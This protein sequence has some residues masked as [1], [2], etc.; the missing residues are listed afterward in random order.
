MDY[1]SIRIP[2]LSNSKIKEKA[3]LFHKDFCDDSIP[4]EIEGIIDLKLKFNIIPVSNLQKL[5]DTDALITSNWDSIYVDSDKFLDERYSNRL[6]FSLAHEIGHFIL[7]KDIYKNFNIKTY[8]DF[9]RLLKDIPSEEY[10]YLESQANKFASHLLIPR[11]KLNNEKIRE[12]KRLESLGKIDD[13]II[14]T[15]LAI[16]IAKLFGVSE[17]AAEIALNDIVSH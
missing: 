9:Y 16:P 10:G 15:Y 13:K 7:H 3:D 2:F 14:N 17:D 6:R 5:L 1:R 11:E 8:E 4:I 12:L